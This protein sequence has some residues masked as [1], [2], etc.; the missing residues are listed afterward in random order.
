MY[1]VVQVARSSVSDGVAA[2]IRSMILDGRL[3]D[4][5]RI[6][7]VRLAAA[8]GV[9]R[10]PLREAL[11]RLAAEGALL[12]VTGQGHRVAPLSVAEFDQLYDIR[13]IL[14]P[15]A[16]AM[17]PLP[18]VEC[19]AEL[20]AINAAFRRTTDGESAIDLDNQWHLLLLAD[21]P[22]RVLVG[23]IE[24]IIAK[25]R[26]YE[27][28]LLRERP[29]VQAAGND[30]DRIMEALRQ[31]DLGAACDLLRHNMQSGKQ[32][33]MNW[34]RARDGRGAKVVIQVD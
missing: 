17:C 14:D 18:S 6:N 29:R 33:V 4:G 30:H 23:M 15:A 20:A 21:C 26:R 22:N 27:L 13:P 5:E 9:S 10:T 19:L 34:L 31:G 7:E 8:L 32:P 16:L 2:A 28:A 24:T 12:N 3:A 1:G 11:N 25:T